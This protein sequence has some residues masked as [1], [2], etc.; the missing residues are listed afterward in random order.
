MLIIFDPH[1]CSNSSWRTRGPWV[2]RQMLD[3]RF[4]RL[5]RD[6]VDP[7]KRGLETTWNNKE[8]RIV[9]HSIR[10]FQPTHDNFIFQRNVPNSW[11]ISFENLWMIFFPSDFRIL[12]TSETCLAARLLVYQE[13]QA[14]SRVGYLPEQSKSRPKQPPLISWGIIK[15]WGGK[16]TSCYQQKNDFT[17]IHN[18]FVYKDLHVFT[19]LDGYSLNFNGFDR[20]FLALDQKLPSCPHQNSFFIPPSSPQS[21]GIIIYSNLTIQ[22]R[23]PE[24]SRHIYTS[25]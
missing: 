18:A 25:I 3:P 10:V 7:W 14:L 4:H 16:Q 20:F 13:D 15:C 12:W 19:F 1:W 9:M 2:K 24:S 6:Q 21:Y 8:Y 17:M 22:Y 23:L 11:Q 5:P